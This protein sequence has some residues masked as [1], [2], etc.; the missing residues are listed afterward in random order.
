M[1][2]FLGDES[3]Y[4]D[5]IKKS[6]KDEIDIVVSCQYRY[7]V[8]ESLLRSHIC[9]NIHYGTLPEFAG[10]NPVYWQIMEG[11]R[12][13]VTLH[14]MDSNFDSG[15]IIADWICPIG[16][17]TA[18]ELYHVLKRK[19]RRLFE[20]YYS[21]ILDGTAPRRKQ[22]LKFRRYRNKK[23]VDFNK[24]KR[25]DCISD[26]TIRATHFRGKQFPVIK[27]GGRE[28]EMVVK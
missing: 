18:D 3:G 13:G 23:D 16:K 2:I 21:K 27:C 15:D 9:V 5:L 20:K 12:A 22:D 14:Y 11:D 7:L 19:G 25:V 26:K 28:Y 17:M 1:I 10:C 8:P 24:E 4:E 6:S